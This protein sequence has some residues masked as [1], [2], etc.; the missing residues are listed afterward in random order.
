MRNSGRIPC[1]VDVTVED[2]PPTHPLALVAVPPT[3][4][5]LR[6][7]MELESTVLFHVELKHAAGP[8]KTNKHARVNLLIQDR[9]P[10][11]YVFMWSAAVI[12]GR[13]RDPT[14]LTQLLGTPESQPV[15]DKVPPPSRDGRVEKPKT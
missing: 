11:T 3:F 12:I 6:F 5:D 1:H 15:P 10:R 8:S 13:L 2:V 9:L 4:F 14:I 7:R